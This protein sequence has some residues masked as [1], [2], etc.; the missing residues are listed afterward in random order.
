MGCCS[1]LRT[2]GLLLIKNF[3][4][5]FRSWIFTIFELILP[6]AYI[7]VLVALRFQ[8]EQIHHEERKW[9]P[10]SI[11]NASNI[12]I[13]SIIP[14]VFPLGKDTNFAN[15][16][17]IILFTPETDEV[18]EIA[19]RFKKMAY[20]SELFFD[21]EFRKNESAM[22]DFLNAQKN[23]SDELYFSKYLGGISLNNTKK[24]NGT[25]FEYRIHFDD[26]LRLAVN[27]SKLEG[28]LNATSFQD[29]IQKI[30]SGKI[31]IHNLTTSAGKSTIAAKG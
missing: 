30:V 17:K 18:K 26:K 4:L 2:V 24:A 22:I 21:V 12:E 25:Q 16:K 7:A 13:S 8:F 15:W 1:C 19:Y 29:L 11:S 14:F 27:A 31:S 23:D 6:V 5:Q 3:V 10:I 20:F 9:E 28:L